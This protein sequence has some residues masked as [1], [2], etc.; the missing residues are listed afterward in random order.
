MTRPCTRQARPSPDMDSRGVH[1]I[2][3]P[4]EDLVVIYSSCE[5]EGKLS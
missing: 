2:I 3:H 1:E 4:V 5:K